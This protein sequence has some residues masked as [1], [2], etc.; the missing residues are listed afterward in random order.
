MKKIR[1]ILQIQTIKN[2]KIKVAAYARVSHNQ[3]LQSLSNQ[4][5]Y[6][7]KLIQNNP[8]W[9]YAG[10]YVD[11]AI[12]GRTT[13]RPEYQRLIKDAIEGKINI[14]LTKSISRFGRDTEETLKTIR[15]LKEKNISVRF[16]KENIDTLTADGELLITLLSALAQEESKSISENLK[17]KVKKKFEQGLPHNPQP[18]LGYR[19]DYETKEY[20]IKEDEADIVREIYKH[21]LE[22]KTIKQIIEI[23]DKQ[24]RKTRKGN[25]FTKSVIHRV[26]GQE[27]YTGK[28]ILQKTYMKKEKGRSV[29]NK[30]E[31]AKYIVENAHESIISQEMFYKAQ[32]KNKRNLH[33]K[34]GE[35]ND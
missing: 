20:K 24:E 12:S 6:Y 22:G 23:L 35:K 16:E 19:W 18:L 1:C 11:Q 26:L 9:E 4:V 30:G 14:I 32:E 21:Y 8:D 29:L 33:N 10:V 25:K 15:N 13:K 34:K 7:N 27:A 2:E 5:S 3:L 17:W 28:L 31:K